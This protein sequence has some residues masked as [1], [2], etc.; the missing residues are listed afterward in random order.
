[1]DRKEIKAQAREKIKNNKWLILKPLLI[2]MAIEFVI[3]FIEGFF[4]VKENELSLV[5]LITSLISLAVTIYSAAYYVYLL[6]FVRNENP[7][8]NDVFECFKEKWLDILVTSLLIVIF[9][10]L[11]SLLFVIP[12]IVASIAYTWALILVVD[13]GMKP[14][15]AIRRSKEIMNGHKWDYFKFCLSFIGWILLTP[16]TFGILLI[17]LIPY[18]MVAEMLYYEKLV[19]GSN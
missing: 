7:T 16:F 4:G 8:L 19:N 13:K 9:V 10:F 2:V 15:E 3:G 1:M 17:W 6:K 5:S 18:I 11:W 12:G 14:T